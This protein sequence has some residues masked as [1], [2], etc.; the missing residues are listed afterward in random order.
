MTGNF[1]EC[2]SIYIQST[3]C[4]AIWHYIVYRWFRN[5]MDVAHFKLFLV[6]FWFFHVFNIVYTGY[7]GWN[8]DPVTKTEQILDNVTTA[9]LFTSL[10]MLWR[11]LYPKKR[12]GVSS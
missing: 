4:F 10:V 6:T 8:L 5:R 11:S 12:K 7:F 3:I 1:E 2:L 9:G